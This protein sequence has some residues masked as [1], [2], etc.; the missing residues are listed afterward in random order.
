MSP[1]DHD[2]DDN[3]PL[4]DIPAM[5]PDRDDVESYQRQ[6]VGKH[7]PAFDPL[8]AAEDE[9]YDEPAGRASNTPLYILAGIAIIAL[10][11]AGFLQ[12]QLASTQSA[13]ESWQLRVGDLEKRLSV[14][15]ESANQSSAQM[16]VKLKEVDESLAKLRDDS[17]KKAKSTLDQHTTQLAALDQTL[18]ATQST[19]A[20]V[21]K[22]VDEQEKTL[23]AA[24]SQLDKLAPTVELSKRKLEE[25]QAAIE[26]LT[27]KGNVTSAN[28][29]K[30]GLRMNTNEEWVQ[31]IN[32]F[33]KQTN[34]EIVNIK[35]QIGGPVSE[36]T[37]K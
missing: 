11:W 2:H 6:K 35:Q 26:S 34:R 12:S 27:E 29:E 4:P 24:K 23:G 9:H 10:G 36:A 30:L 7:K 33:R 13:L 1:R 17:F 5:V 21:E 22:A 20:K 18:K 15:D 32:N 19:A 8:P 37:P 25:Q 28:V 31:S 16:Q 3:D 14:T